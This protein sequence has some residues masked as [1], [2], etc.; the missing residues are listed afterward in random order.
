MEQNRIPAAQPDHLCVVAVAAAVDSPPS[1][2]GHS[3]AWFE[4]CFPGA[5]L[6]LDPGSQALRLERG[7]GVKP[8]Y[9]QIQ[10]GEAW[11]CSAFAD[12]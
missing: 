6:I 11:G 12:G 4:V 1:L 7:R 3:P 9:G 8:A 10:I 5:T 2:R